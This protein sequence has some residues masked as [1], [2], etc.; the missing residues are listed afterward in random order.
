MY[1]YRRLR[2]CRYRIQIQNKEYRTE[3]RIRAK[4]MHINLPMY[5]VYGASTK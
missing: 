3:Y 5:L 4:L 2:T 1:M